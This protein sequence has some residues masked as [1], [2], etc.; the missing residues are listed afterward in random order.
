MKIKA[1]QAIQVTFIASPLE[2][3]ESLTLMEFLMDNI[4]NMRVNNPSY[5][6]LKPYLGDDKHLLEHEDGHIR[7]DCWCEPELVHLDGDNYLLHKNKDGKD[8]TTEDAVKN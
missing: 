8:I 4:P 2:D 3:M 6:E 1:R 5:R 7:I